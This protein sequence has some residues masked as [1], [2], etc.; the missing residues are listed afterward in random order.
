[1]KMKTDRKAKNNICTLVT[2]IEFLIGPAGGGYCA[3]PYPFLDF[4][5][6]L[7]M[8]MGGKWEKGS[9]VGGRGEKGKG[10]EGREK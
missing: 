2:I 9:R 8:G 1:M 6:G 10:G 7:G 3:F 5:E 4:G